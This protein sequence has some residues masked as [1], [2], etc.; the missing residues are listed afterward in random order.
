MLKSLANQKA[1]PTWS[2]KLTVAMYDKQRPHV[3]NTGPQL[4][5]PATQFPS[6]PQLCLQVQCF[7]RMIGHHYH[8]EF[9]FPLLGAKQVRFICMCCLTLHLLILLLV[10]ASHYFFCQRFNLTMVCSPQLVSKATWQFLSTEIQALWL[11]AVSPLSKKSKT[12]VWL[13][14]PGV[15][16]LI[17]C[18]GPSSWLSFNPGHAV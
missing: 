12:P 8:F 17:S 18:S 3:C 6:E 11:N 7:G 15:F 9:C 16:K 2:L 14:S 1:V 5:G 13:D 4:E 10:E